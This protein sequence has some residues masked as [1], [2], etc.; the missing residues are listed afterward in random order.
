MC[1]KEVKYYFICLICGKK[2]CCTTSCNLSHNHVRNC[3]GKMGMFIYITDMRLYFIN[4][5]NQK[6]V[7]FP[8]YVNESGVGPD[9]SNKG[10]N[11]KLSKE[12]YETAL[13]E[14]ISLNVKI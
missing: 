3:C 13:K 5:E 2:I 6:K 12:N 10:R 9:L 1:N 11:F 14:F 4:S 7:F 8:L